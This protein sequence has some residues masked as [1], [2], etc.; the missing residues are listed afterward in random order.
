MNLYRKNAFF[1]GCDTAV[2]QWCILN[3]D[4]P[5][6]DVIFSVLSELQRMG[7]KSIVTF[8]STERLE[9]FHY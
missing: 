6:V 7:I 9:N 8:Y 4:S 2:Y 1:V 5:N 3:Q